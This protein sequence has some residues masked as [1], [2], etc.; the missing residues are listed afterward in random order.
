M[1]KFVYVEFDNYEGCYIILVKKIY[2]IIE[3]I[4]I[5]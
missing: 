5:L 3:L 4:Y 2:L 1:G